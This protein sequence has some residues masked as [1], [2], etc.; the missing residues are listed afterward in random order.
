MYSCCCDIDHSIAPD[1]STDAVV[2][3]VAVLVNGFGV[4]PAVKVIDTS[5]DIRIDQKRPCRYIE[6]LD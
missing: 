2:G 6:E 5:V 3:G 4:D 1:V